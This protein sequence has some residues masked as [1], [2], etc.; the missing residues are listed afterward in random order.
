[1][2]RG[3]E[4]HSDKL[5]EGRFGKLENLGFVWLSWVASVPGE[6]CVPS[7]V[8]RGEVHLAEFR[9]LCPCK[10]DEVHAS[11][12]CKLCFPGVDLVVAGDIGGEPGLL[13][14]G[15]AGGKF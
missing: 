2:D 15:V 11:W 10:E 3:A 13:R 14:E 7:D 5:G 6:G 4:E 9:R 8:V 1:L 12:S